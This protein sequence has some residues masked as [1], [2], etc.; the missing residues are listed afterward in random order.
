MPRSPRPG[1]R[2]ASRQLHSACSSLR[3]RADTTT[4]SPNPR[5]CTT[6]GKT[7][8]HLRAF[9]TQTQPRPHTFANDLEETCPLLAAD[10]GLSDAMGMRAP[11]P[12]PPRRP[13]PARSSSSPSWSTAPSGAARSAPT[14][15]MRTGVPELGQQPR[16]ATKSSQSPPVPSRTGW[17]TDTG[18][19]T[20]GATSLSASSRGRRLLSCRYDRDGVY[21]DAR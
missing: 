1:D 21:R 9:R 10:R 16:S 12:P 6:A 11:A 17:W 14:S 4:P 7:L 18:T 13:R 19:D 5:I 8:P 15:P 20:E 3:Y 2:A